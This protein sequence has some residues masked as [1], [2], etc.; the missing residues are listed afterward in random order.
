M[1]FW[2]S[3]MKISVASSALLIAILLLPIAC[4]SGAS[5]DQSA[6]SEPKIST[7]PSPGPVLF[8][9]KPTTTKEP[10]IQQ[11]LASY[12]SHGK[13]ALFRIQLH[14]PKSSS[15]KTS[16]ILFG[17]GRFLSEPVSDS[18][19]ML[20]DLQKAL[21]AKSLPKNVKREATLPFTYATLG[22]HQSRS[23]DDSFSSK[24]S[25]NWNAM[26]IFITTGDEESE[27]FMNLNPTDGKGEFSIKDSD[28][29]DA[30]LGK[31][32]SIL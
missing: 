18:S 9:L 2:D 22:E 26:K 7:A 16:P 32:A 29:G 10:D 27:V 24:P 21:E 11:W 6:T 8:T 25:G 3:P 28:Y 13:T 1:V 14:L 20:A 17:R 23:E 15:D 4:K 12:T 5:R 31:L 30:I 19:V